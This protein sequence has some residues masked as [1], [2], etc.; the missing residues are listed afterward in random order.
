[1][2]GHYLATALAKIR[3]TPFTT[4][5]NI[6]TLAMG[7]ACFIAAW[8]IATWWQSGDTYHREAERTFVVGQA[9][10][11]HGQADSAL[12]SRSA[13]VAARFLREDFPEFDEIASI[14]WR[15]QVPVSA[16]DRKQLLNFAFAD[17]AF[18]RIF[19]FDFITGSKDALGKPGSVVL[20]E[21]AARRLFGST[22]A[23]G[24]SV[25]IDTTRDATVTG[26]IRAVRQPSFMG[27]G[28]DAEV[29]FDM[30]ADWDSV[31]HDNIENWVGT[32][33]WTFV[34]LK[35]GVT[36][37]DINRRL[38]DFVQ[39]RVP[40]ENLKLVGFRMQLFP[41]SEIST[42]TL[43]RVL[44]A[45]NGM[46]LT[47]VS[48]LL[49][50][51]LLTL[52]VACANYASLATAQAASRAKEFGMRRVVGAGIGAVMMQ[53]W[54][55]ALVLTII[56]LALAI[57]VLA[58]ASPFIMSSA[59]IDV[60]YFLTLGPKSWALVAGIVLAAAAVAGAYPALILSRIRPA[61]ALRSGKSRSGP[62]FVASILVGI[63]FASASFLLILVTV[64]QQQRVH[65]E[66]AALA[67]HSDPIIALNNILPLG[68]TIDMLETELKAIPGVKSVTV[69]DRLPWTSDGSVIGLARTVDPAASAPNA[70]LKQVGYNYFETLDLGLVAGRTFDRQHE[71]KPNLMLAANGAEPIPVVVDRTFAEAMAFPSPAAA[72]GQVV[73]LPEK[74]TNM[75]QRPRQSV[76]IIGVVEA[77]RMRMGATPFT[78][79]WYIYAPGSAIMGEAQ[80]PSVKI[81][82]ENVAETLKAIETA[83]TK[84]SPEVPLNV[85]FLDQLFEQSYRQFARIGQVFIGLA[86]AAFAIAS[87]GLLG[88]AVHVAVKRRHEVA[89]RKTLGSSAARVVGLLLT[90]F[91]KPV[92]I[93]NVI[94]WPLAWVA[95]NAY[96][97]S[98]AN[99]IDLTVAP[100][101]V[102]MGLTLL[103]AWAAV[104]GVV[105][106]AATVH[107]ASV[108]RRA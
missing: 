60:L 76:R 61:D 108:L 21:D 45:S 11:P 105:L 62:G 95:A 51:G 74:L 2:F 46:G 30:I 37:G 103:L 91:S 17:P 48:V 59:S 53:A 83:W 54:L 31:P 25:R 49:G 55:E 58:V 72:V 96:L 86:I 34:A 85:S 5:A 100:F 104:I 12:G 27:A 24:Q 88:I 63:Q 94:A 97:A 101:L 78:G 66:E 75:F 81:A 67:P 87:V 9:L 13:V 70:F 90:D 98:F 79:N 29:N 44:F 15:P 6:V 64:A 39:R 3:K 20:T 73:W 77:D 102:S 19:D 14:D 69:S 50:L 80:I 33:G 56:A 38:P 10:T 84:L 36:V 89:V 23:L 47:A 93:G 35:P 68:I 107:P 22:N 42:R 8:G 40:P 7:L 82:K 65:L 71:I 41:V 57:G 28:R 4:F 43:D 16:G 32:S 106:K 52:I 1:M 18:L 26:V 99:R 92:L